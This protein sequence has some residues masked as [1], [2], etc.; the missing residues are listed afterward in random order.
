[1]I[2]EL[3]KLFE[4]IKNISIE[5]KDEVLEYL[6]LLNFEDYL[7][8]LESF[9]HN[10]ISKV[11]AFVYKNAIL[12]IQSED[13]SPEIAHYFTDL[14]EQTL[15]AS[16]PPFSNF[17]EESSHISQIKKL[18]NA[19]YYAHLTFKDLENI[20]VRDIS[21]SRKDLNLLLSK[22]IE[23]A[24][25]ASFLATH[26]D[27]DIKVLFQEEIELLLPYLKQ[28][29]D[30]VHLKSK[31]LKGFID[32]TRKNI[33]NAS[34]VTV[35]LDINLLEVS[36]EHLD[37][38][39]L[40]LTHI[41]QFAENC[42]ET[43]DELIRKAKTEGQLKINLGINLVGV[44]SENKEF[45][46][47][48]LHPIEKL[49]TITAK[50]I[51]PAYNLGDISGLTVDHLRPLGS[52]MD[53]NLITKLG[54]RLPN[55]ISQLT[56]YIQN[57]SSKIKSNQPGLNQEKLDEL[58]NTALNLL[59]DLENLQ[60]NNLFISLKFLNYIHIIRH[61]ITLSMSTMEQIGELNESTQDLVR[62][63][64]AQLKYELLPTLFGLVD[65]IE[66]SSTRKAGVFS[67][68]LMTQVKELYEA[69]LYFPRKVI[70][71]KAKGEEL[72]SIEDSRFVELRLNPAY[73][74][75]DEA[76]IALYKNQKMQEALNAFFNILEKEKY[77]N[78]SLHE[79]PIKIKERLITHYKII[80]P[81]V[82]Q[83]DSD[84]NDHIITS[85]AGTQPWSF[86][87]FQWPGAFPINHISHIL[88]RKKALQ[89][90]ITKNQN[91]Q[92]FHIKLNKDLI[93][94]V[95]QD[96]KLVL[97]PYVNALS[98]YSLDE[99]IPLKHYAEQL[100]FKKSGENNHLEDPRQLNAL[101]AIELC[102][103][104]RNKHNQF[105]VV[106]KEYAHFMELLKTYNIYENILDILKLDEA[107]KTQLLKSYNAIQSYFIDGVP[108]ERKEWALKFDNYLVNLLSNKPVDFNDKPT[109][110][111]FFNLHPHLENH[112]AKFELKLHKKNQHHFIIAQKKFDSENKA[113]PLEPSKN[114][115]PRAHHL[116]S[117]TDI[118]QKIQG[119]RSDLSL[120]TKLFNHPMQ[121]ELTPKKEK[122]I[123][124]PE[125]EDLKDEG[126]HLKQPQQVRAIKDLYNGLFHLEEIALQL[127]K[128]TDD[129]QSPTQSD[130][131]QYKGFQ[132]YFKSLF[133]VK[134]HSYT[135]YKKGIYV[136]HLVIAYTHV[137]K[138]IKAT[139]RLALDPHYGFITK[140]LMYKAQ[141][142]YALI[143]EQTGAY[144]TTPEQI[145][146]QETVQFSSLWYAL[147]TFEIS[148]KQIRALNNTQYLTTE[149][150]NNLHER[151]KKATLTIQDLI[152]NSDSYFKLFL[153]T[154]QMLA[155][156]R[157]LKQKFNEFTTTA[158][159]AVVGNLEAIR[160]NLLTPMLMEADRWEHHFGVA[161]GR[162]S[163]PLRTI[164]DEYYKGL[165]HSLKLH[166]KKH[167]ALVCDP[168]PLMQRKAFINKEFEK[169]NKKY[170]KYK[171]SFS[172]IDALYKDMM[173]H[174]KMIGGLWPYT[175]KQIEESQEKIQKQYNKIVPK[176]TKLK[177]KQKINTEPS[178]YASDHLFDDL[179]NTSLKE[180]QPH[181]T[182]I[183][184]LIRVT[185]HYYTGLVATYNLNINT[186]Q[187]KQK[188]LNLIETTQKQEHQTFIEIYTAEAF[189]KHLH[190]LCNRHN[191]LQRAGS[192]YRSELEKDLRQYK[193]KIINDSKTTE[194]IN[195]TIQLLLKE[196]IAIFEKRNFAKYYQLDLVF[197]ALSKFKTYFTRCTVKK[198]P[199]FENNELLAQKSARINKL[200]II[201]TRKDLSVEER[202][203]KIRD[204]VK[205]PNFARIILAHKAPDILS[206]SYLR[207]CFLCLLQTLHL[208]TPTRKK[209]WN[210]LN[211]SVKNPP[212]MGK[213]A[214]KFGL[215]YKPKSE[216]KPELN[217]EAKP[218]I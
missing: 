192:E 172:L 1:M 76:N 106:Q 148:P 174:K 14:N 177:I 159:D 41:E 13:A 71:F 5:K 52:E 180:Y 26:L 2:E 107:I 18:L 211:L 49:V 32:K 58:R 158:H 77:K 43:V 87:P 54:G 126:I 24:Y 47:L 135:K 100:V 109:M 112:F 190:A 73:R 186:L 125:M 201:A 57:Y 152:N 206:F 103:W 48:H 141:K 120:L 154:P 118:S 205:D 182:E 188:Y 157:E 202:I 12:T 61:I 184:N 3:T 200:E 68:D 134:D 84:F 23:T 45:I 35:N 29:D 66:L 210:D 31:N 36:K 9:K 197:D 64:L 168:T 113:T 46:Q 98:V 94:F 67:K 108:K 63:Q 37:L 198:K 19:L 214:S 150:L 92:L 163:G 20:N 4:S 212:R 145:L 62:N 123:P 137:D 185:H 136:F 216:E 101:Q 117:T 30:F 175:S 143:K 34:Y 139:K 11:I 86:K 176:L 96:T 15:N 42:P 130:Y 79:L 39:Q 17:D 187:E 169:S 102:H 217:P 27:V 133:A 70:D 131:E 80:K 164:L 204:E 196:K 181:F 127:E 195:H 44:S 115:D 91:S 178:V 121:V 74:R 85:L 162:F 56:Q 128:L 140:E 215:F 90:L 82:V 203:A 38:I 153:Q 72:L 179:C 104:Y 156:Y 155:L 81:L 53:Y 151:A 59:N 161:P 111:T 132:Y 65:K 8:T 149:E 33:K 167:I 119:L 25:E 183:E 10:Q 99:S 6:K 142:I 144:Q 173:A 124:F 105:L 207:M 28:I 89:T 16:Y 93:D 170:E 160:S 208:F 51:P 55:Y 199:L 110:K 7:R 165:L 22:T 50:E 78:L 209:L 40:H 166:S 147:N 95:Y 194:D 171:Y 116:F 193:E 138:I 122:G 189:H 218:S 213:L 60:G 21:C 83:L 114:K 129:N 191:G 97:F 88:T 69:I 75:I 146:P